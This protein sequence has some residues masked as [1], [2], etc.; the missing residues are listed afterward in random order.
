MQKPL[1][2]VVQ[3][4]HDLLQHEQKLKA[5]GKGSGNKA[6][7]QSVALAA[8]SYS[9]TGS[10]NSN[11]T[12]KNP[13][14]GNGGGE[15]GTYKGSGSV[16][17]DADVEGDR[18]SQVEVGSRF[19]NTTGGFT[20]EEM[21]KLRTL[22]QSSSSSSP[23]SPQS[24]AINHRSHSV[25]NYLPQFPSYAGPSDRQEDWFGKRT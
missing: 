19:S 12:T 14:K 1:P 25:T 15:T 9:G 23:T 4:F 3:A 11:S 2:T 20:A 7:T 21:N 13:Y 8:G 6:T 18:N 5:Y 16:A 17:Q 10:S 24:P 22:L